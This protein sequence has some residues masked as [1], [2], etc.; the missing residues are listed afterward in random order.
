[1]RRP[2]RHRKKRKLGRLRSRREDNHK[3]DLKEIRRDN[4]ERIH[5]A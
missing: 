5:L 2:L 4:V 1:M 3:V